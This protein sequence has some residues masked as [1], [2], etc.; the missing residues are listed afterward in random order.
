MLKKTLC[1]VPGVLLALAVCL[2]LWGCTRGFDLTDEGAYYLSFVQPGEIRHAVSADYLYGGLVFDALA[3]NIV[4]MRWATLA[5]YLLASWVLA[6]GVRRYYAGFLKWAGAGTGALFSCVLLGGLPVFYAPV[7]LSYNMLNGLGVM[8]SGGLLLAAA[9]SKSGALWFA[10][11]LVQGMLFFVKLSTGLLLPVVTVLWLLAT[12]RAREWREGLLAL[13]L[14]LAGMEVWSV[15]HFVCIM[16]MTSWWGVFSGLFRSA[17]GEYGRRLAA[18]C[19]RQAWMTLPWLLGCAGLAICVRVAA[20]RWNFRAQGF[21]ERLRPW[22]WGFAGVFWS[23]ILGSGGY[24]GGYGNEREA[25]GSLLALCVFYGALAAVPACCLVCETGRRR[26]FERWAGAGLLFVLPW[27]GAAGTGNVLMMNVGYQQASWAA[28]ALLAS[29]AAGRLVRS[30]RYQM[31]SWLAIAALMFSQFASGYLLHP[32]RLTENRLQQTIPVP[33]GVPGTRLL[34]DQPTAGLLTQIRDALAANGF[35][36]GD[37]LLAFFDLPGVVYAVGG[38]SP[39]IPWYFGM[40]YETGLEL[41]KEALA[42][43][44][45][46]RLA[47]VFIV[48]RFGLENARVDKREKVFAF[49]RFL[50]DIGLDVPASYRLC[51]ET[52]HW[53]RARSVLEH[54]R[55]RVWKPAGRTAAEV[56]GPAS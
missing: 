56:S 39:G 6:R 5:L 10:A 13:A 9:R 20:V 3:R 46:N 40:H 55:V 32:Y 54:R 29:A 22:V 34:L 17:F 38:V 24:A 14:F 30:S 36:P 15:V 48:E 42:S 41:D 50:R 31:A 26:R 19:M 1:A 37:D 21:G 28:L 11:G 16:D 49:I 51:L 25:T 45:Q 35:C 7:C 44:S 52:E 18:G 2:C 43:V 47:G 4:W 33:V 12:V 23:L 27:I 8:A 53:Y